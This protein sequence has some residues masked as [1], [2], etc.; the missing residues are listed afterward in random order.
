M[1]EKA[2]EA[3]LP[4]YEVKL[5]E[6]MSQWYD[7][8]VMKGFIQPPFLLDASK[9]ERLEGYFVVGLTPAEGAQAFFGTVH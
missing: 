6:W 4:Q 2:I 9:A 8:S 1:D 5:R 3:G 7:H